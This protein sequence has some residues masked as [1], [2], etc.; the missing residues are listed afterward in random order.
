MLC[1]HVCEDLAVPAGGDLTGSIPSVTLHSENAPIRF[2]LGFLTEHI[3]EKMTSSL[4]MRQ[5]PFQPLEADVQH[6][7]VRN[8]GSSMTRGPELISGFIQA[9]LE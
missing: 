9:L 1:Q 8:T 3:C 5:L 6:W 7:N 2:H 4:G